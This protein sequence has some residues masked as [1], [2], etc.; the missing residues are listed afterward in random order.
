MTES[1][2]GERFWENELDAWVQYF[3]R[4]VEG[5]GD[6]F[7]QA[8]EADVRR[9]EMLAGFPFP[10]EFRVFLRRMGRT[11]IGALDPFMENYVYGVDAVAAFY[12]APPVPAPPG[13]VYLWTLDEDLEMFLDTTKSP[14]PVIYC[15]WAYD[16]ETGK[17]IP[18]LHRSHVYFECDSLIKYLYFEAFRW[19]RTRQ[20][21]HQV[22]L[23]RS[24]DPADG[25]VPPL[26]QRVAQFRELAGR[27]GF[28]PV[29]Y[30][31]D[32]MAFY[33]RDDATLAGYPEDGSRDTVYIR[34]ASERELGR[35]REIIADRFGMFVPGE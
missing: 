18:G 3:A 14:H 24:T 7:V 17:P 32:D 34:A 29:P 31:T 28:T 35:L 12:T 11:P 19:L 30:M 16:E 27:L 6:T 26:A 1:M 23:W 20:L 5:F 2:H 4:H 21:A 22:Q 8:S 9:L 10:P 13:A 25:P 33:N 15:E